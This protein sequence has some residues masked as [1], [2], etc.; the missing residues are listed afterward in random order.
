MPQD[1]KPKVVS[2]GAE[3]QEIEDAKIAAAKEADMVVE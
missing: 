1:E 3:S 2:D